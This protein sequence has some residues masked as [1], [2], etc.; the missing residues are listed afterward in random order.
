MRKLQLLTLFLCL[1]ALTACGYRLSGFG[2]EIPTHVKSIVIPDFDNKTTRIQAEQFV[3]Y[4]VKDEFIRRS[5]LELL[6]SRYGADSILEG[7]IIAFD[8]TP[9]SYSRDASANV[10]EIRIVLNVR[11]IDLKENKV[12]F[13]GKSIA[14]NA[15]YDINSEEDSDFFS[16]ENRKLEEIAEKFAES[17]VTS[18]LENF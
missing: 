5:N 16:Q 17:V 11:F 12:I 4:A 14:F 13:E 8:V 18:I 15:N 3:T 2:K 9:V 1:A 6:S 7:E 10:Y